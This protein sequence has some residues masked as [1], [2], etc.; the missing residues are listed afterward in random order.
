LPRDVGAIVVAAGQGTRIGGVPK[1]YRLL[2]GVPL[3]LRALRPFTAHRD[4]AHVVLVLPPADAA[5]PPPFLSDLAGPG[6]TLVA[7][8]AERADSVAAGLAALAPAC[9]IVLVHDA[10]R[11]FVEAGVIDAV[12]QEA[13]AGV[14]AVAAVPLSDTVKEVG[15]GDRRVLRTVPREHLWR[16]QTPQGFPRSLL[17]EAH[18]RARGDGVRATDDAALVERLGATVRVVPDSPS[19]LKIT[20]PEDFA[21]AEAWVAARG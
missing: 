21:W 7:G 5:A 16:A 6:L 15:A 18:E 9:T 2:G 13:R 14:G 4:V 10:A 17:A 11:P 1:Q 3:V 12:I 19:N 20:T 8:G